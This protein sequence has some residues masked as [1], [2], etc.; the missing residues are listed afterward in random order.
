MSSTR[1]LAPL[2]RERRDGDI[3]PLGAYGPTRKADV[4]A[5]PIPPGVGAGAPRAQS[6]NRAGNEPRGVAGRD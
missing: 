6:I 5:R 3:S 4:I 2:R 1:Q